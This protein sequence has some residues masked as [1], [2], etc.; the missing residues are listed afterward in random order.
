[1]SLRNSP[2]LFGFND[3]EVELKSFSSYFIRGKGGLITSFGH[4]LQSMHG[5]LL[6]YVQYIKNTDL[7]IS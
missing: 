7:Y 5:Q 2:D 4:T 1:V 6:E 3:N